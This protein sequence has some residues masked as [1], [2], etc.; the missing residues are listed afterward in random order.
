MA[1]HYNY[2]LVIVS[3]LVACF[4]SFTAIEMNLAAGKLQQHSRI[5]H[6]IK[7]AVSLGLGVWAM[8][9]IAMLAH[10]MNMDVSYD[11]GLTILSLLVAIG[12]ALISFYVAQRQQLNYGML[13][14]AS[15]AMGLGIAGMHY[16]GMAAMIMDATLIYNTNLVLASVGIAILVSFAAIF[17]LRFITNNPSFNSLK[18]KTSC[19]LIM[20]A[21]VASMHYTGMAATQ[22]EPLEIIDI[23]HISGIDGELL[24]LSISIISIIILGSFLLLTTSSLKS[25]ARKRMALLILIMAGTTISS[26]AVSINILYDTSFKQR[27]AQMSEF[28]RSQARMMEAVISFD[29]INSEDA[30]PK[31]ALAASI[32]Q[33]VDA[34][35]NFKGHT[36]TLKFYMLDTA[37]TIP[38]IRFQHSGN[39]IEEDIRVNPE[40][41]DGKFFSR[42]VRSK[43]QHLITSDPYTG[44]KIIAVKEQVFDSNLHIIGHVDIDEI[45]QP[46]VIAG[47]TTLLIDIFI[48]IIGASVFSSISSPIIRNLESEISSRKHAEKELQ[49]THEQL[50]ERIIERTQEL[51]ATTTSLQKEMTHREEIESSLRKSN[52]FHERLMDS[53]TN[54]IFVLDIDRRFISLNPHTCTLTG[55]EYGD[56]IQHPID[57]LFVVNEFDQFVTDFQSAWNNGIV[58]HNHKSI[59]I[60]NNG[61]YRWV[62]YSLSPIY[63][64]G[65]IE[66]IVGTFDDITDQKKAEENLIKAK[67]VAEGANT[68]KSEFLANMS[69][70]IRTP[71]NGVLGMLNLLRDTNLDKTQHDFAE[72]AYSSAEVLLVLLN[73]ILDLSKI[74]AGKMELEE[75][76]FDIRETLEDVA[77]LLAERAHSKYLEIGCDISQEFPA[78]VSG[79]PVRFRQI[80]TN[81]LG[82]AI[83]FTEKGEVVVHAELQQQNDHEIQIKIAVRDTGIGISKEAQAKIFDA[84][85]QEDGT[86]TRRFGGT[87]LG[88]S[89]TR[90]LVNLMDGEMQVDS[91]PDQGSTFWFVASFKPAKNKHIEEQHNMQLNNYRALIVDDTEV[92]RTILQHQLDSWGITHDSAINGKEALISIDKAHNSGNPYDIILLDMM[93][94]EVNGIG[95]AESV[96][97]KYQDA[98]P[99]ILL[100]T[101]TTQSLKKEVSRIDCIQASLTK[102]VKQSLLFDYIYT[103][104]NT[105]QASFNAGTTKTT[106]KSDTSAVDTR[107]IKN[108]NILVAEDNLINQKV[109]LGILSK[110]GLTVTVADNGA[111]AF[112][113][114]EKNAYDLIFMDCQMPVM[115]GYE[116]TQK[117]RDYENSI[118]RKTPIIALTAN[119]MKNDKEACFAAGMDDYLAKPIKVELLTSALQKWLATAPDNG[120][121]ENVING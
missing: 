35:R 120:S 108:S 14:F 112:A 117:I 32:S 33:F 25:T 104:L 92:N 115:D 101:S 59:L 119:A 13:V 91:T 19:A 7:S 20:G 94:P 97:N 121:K 110:L 10:D 22:F 114:V 37:D 44:N 16:I 63:D 105:E 93:M 82:N 109:I 95:V 51:Q 29:A 23:N 31:G 11:I 24:A 103:T 2:Y 42:L 56:L 18:L 17:L 49:A 6:H 79:D 68:A 9:F 36:E 111:E 102:P 66:N 55:F 86:T 58:T 50:E 28:L 81:L 41:N 88:L 64:Q 116:A 89:I 47:Y 3:Y 60:T 84:F 98:A 38:L 118:G 85:S 39:K 26:A 54:A 48:I 40:K 73:D 80:I 69:H 96:Q 100:L 62:S 74:E 65:K 34:H 21:A 4:A 106:E 61:D 43:R 57:E 83:K 45:K 99:K 87:G 76:D 8:H 52:Q 30:N 70:E 27:T 67:E 75:I 53:T 77:S 1:A 107:M 15:I 113:F 12:A 71:M 72:T 5:S 78:R 46:F 90:Q